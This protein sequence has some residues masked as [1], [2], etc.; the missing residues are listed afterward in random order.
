[1]SKIEERGIHQNSFYE[2]NI[3]LIPK[4]T[5]TAHKKRKLQAKITHEIDEK[6]PQQNIS[7]QD[8][9]IH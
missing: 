1:M 8:S 6:N 7:K 4:P 3:T 2:A 9:T 5:K